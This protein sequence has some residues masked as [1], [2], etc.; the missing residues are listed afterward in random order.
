MHTEFTAILARE[1]ERHFAHCAESSRSQRHGK[2]V[3]KTNLPHALY[4][5]TR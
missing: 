5:G 2:S 4:S 3:H 1:G